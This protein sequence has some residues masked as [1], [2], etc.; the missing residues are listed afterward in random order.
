MIEIDLISPSN[1][2]FDV[3]LG[4][5]SVQQVCSYKLIFTDTT[6]IN[7]VVYDRGTITYYLLDEDG[8]E[9]AI[10][11]SDKG[12]TAIGDFC[13]GGTFNIR[14]RITIRDIISGCP[15]PIIY[16][17]YLDGQVE[18]DEWFPVLDLGTIDCC[19]KKDTEFTI[20]PSS[21]ALNNNVCQTTPTNDAGFFTENPVNALYTIDAIET[22]VAPNTKLITSV[23]HGLVN[24]TTVVI[25][26]AGTPTLNGSFVIS[27]VTTDTFVITAS[28]TN[29]NPSSATFTA[30]LPGRF[31][32]TGFSTWNQTEQILKYEL[33]YYDLAT[34]IWIEEAEITYGVPTANP[35]DYPFTYTPNR[36]TR[37]RLKASLTNCCTTIE[38]EL[39]FAICDAIVITPSCRGQIE[40]TTCNTYYIDNYTDNDITV[41]IDD[42]ITNK[43]IHE[44]VI[45]ANTRYTH[46]FTEDGVYNVQY[47]TDREFNIVVPI[48]CQI[49][50]CYTDLMKVLLCANASKDCC[51]DQYL[52]N[53]LA[54]VQAFYQTFLQYIAPYTDLNLRFANSDITSMLSDFT[55]I[56]K[57]RNQILDF[58]DVCRRNCNGCFDYGKGTCI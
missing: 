56:G 53:R 28:G 46:S 50:K 40:C 47:A 35:L 23:D 17:E 30:L 24:N 37:Y 22:G 31:I 15:G 38:D 18:L 3:V 54:N 52:E 55:K 32:T 48:L 49:D 14:Q 10:G 44:V 42:L 9:T 29:E 51:D 7:N 26:G 58:C 5:T 45:T 33:E 16:Q 43:E 11:T 25:S 39:E 36:L 6:T 2:G 4:N 34:G 41:K 12:S 19:Y 21:I 57:L 20:Y 8:N 1:P 13:E 27:S